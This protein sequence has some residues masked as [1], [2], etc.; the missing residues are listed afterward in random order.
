MKMQN[1]IQTHQAHR[2]LQGGRQPA[3]LCAFG[4]STPE[5]VL[6]SPWKGGFSLSLPRSRLSPALSNPP[7][8]CGSERDRG[9]GRVSCCSVFGP[10]RSSTCI[11]APG[12]EEHLEN[13]E[14]ET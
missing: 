12:S 2:Y 8:E 10:H 7:R 5:H 14:G 1:Q 9:G 3:L 6:P 11:W 4:E 13:V